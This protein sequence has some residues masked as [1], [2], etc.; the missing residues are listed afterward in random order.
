MAT[1]RRL[2]EERG[3]DRELR[4][5]LMGRLPVDRLAGLLPRLLS[6]P[7]D[8][9]AVDVLA[10]AR[11]QTGPATV[12]EYV[13][14]G[15]RRLVA[16]PAPGGVEAGRRTAFFREV[17]DALIAG[18][19]REDREKLSAD[20]AQLLGSTGAT[21]PVPAAAPPP[22]ASPRRLTLILDRLDSS[23]TGRG[24]GHSSALLGEAVVTAALASTSSAELETSL[25]EMRE[26]GLFRGT[27][28]LFRVLVQ[29]LPAWPL[30]DLTARTSPAAV[31]LER[32][33]ALAPDARQATDRF[34]ELVEAGA[35]TFNQGALERAELVFSVAERLL[36]R[37]A[38]EASAVEPL[39]AGGHERL[40]LERIRRLLE[41]EDRREVPRSLLRFYRVFDPSALLDKLRREPARQ[42]RRLLLAFLE[43]HGTDGRH[44]AFERLGRRPE[45]QQDVFLGRNLIHL[46]RRIPGDQ[47]PWMPARELGRVVRF[48]V[49]E[50]P[51][52]LVREVLAYLAEKRHPVAE[53]ALRQFVTT[54]EEA[55]LGEPPDGGST[56]R[57]QWLG[58]LDETCAALARHGTPGAW[59]AVVDHGLRTEPELGHPAARLVELGGHNLS[60]QPELV[61]QLVTAA[62]AEIPR[63]LLARPTAA[64]AERLRHVVAALADTRTAE[65]QELLETLAGHFPEED[66]GRR[67]ARILANA[68]TAGGGFDPSVGATLSG[69]LR[70]FGLPTLLQS[71]A[72]SRVT[73]VLR[74]V[75][76]R[77]GSLATVE[78]ERGL[79]ATARYGTL[80]GPEVVYQLLERPV[81]ATFVFVPRAASAGLAGTASV[82][83]SKRLEDMTPLLLEG[84]RRHDEL[85]RASVVV[86]DD[87]RLA[88]TD[89]PPRAVTGEDDIDLVISLWEKVA[90]GTTPRQCEQTLGADAYRVRR[91]LV[92]WVE[93]G[94][95]E[96]RGGAGAGETG[97]TDREQ[98][99]RFDE[100]APPKG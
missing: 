21:P 51:P 16:L 24:K 54:L 88:T 41:G 80:E 23:A 25:S 56:D 89:R 77:G 19:P 50:N 32:L 40:D 52:F 90:A 71:L 58:Y 5:H 72:D 63:R 27:D 97:R 73:G 57:H 38:V 22:A 11:G 3:A 82:V 36:D 75:G 7:T 55:L 8:K 45:D 79:L 94:A 65:V 9:V 59:R 60:A 93:D 35:S 85:R 100:A 83:S 20:A 76:A 14:A 2:A 26:R 69:D 74:L 84:L 44:A 31:A 15:L 33:V 87:A 12:R 1:G 39:R 46:L 43:A 98:R 29:A 10:W 48:L 78:L 64:Q 4:L 30:P 61:S 53:Q 49:P 86:P 68:G 91:C 81:R 18:S 17:A 95:L 6:S 99:K 34:Y 47:S 62:V 96:V 70:V 13:S 28:E 66:F 92:D 67:A 37:R 42:R